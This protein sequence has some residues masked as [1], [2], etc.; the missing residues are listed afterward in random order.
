MRLQQHD[1]IRGKR[2]SW[3]RRRHCSS[4]LRVGLLALAGSV[5]QAQSFLPHTDGVVHEVKLPGE[6][7]GPTT[8]S[9]AADGRLWFTLSSGNAIGRVEADGSNYVQF[10]LPQPGSSPRIIALGS[11]GNLWFS[12]HDGGRMGRITPEGVISEWDLPTPDS[13]PRAIALG[14]DGNIWVGQFAAGSIARITPQGEITEFAIPTPDSGPRALAAGPDGNIWFSEF[15][16]GKIGRIT[17]QGEITEFALPRPNTGPGD[18]T[19]GSDGALWFLEL[20]GSMDGMQKDG[21]RVGR[22]TVEGEITEY[23]IPSEGSTPVNIALG[24]DGNI[25][26]TKNAT[27][28]RVTPQGEITEFP[29]AEGAARAV[30]LSAGADREPPRRLIDRLWFTDPVNNRIAYLQFSVTAP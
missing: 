8:L 11:D 17:P 26:Y 10:D 24:P 25:W 1:N 28:G 12:Q 20:G 15:K 18:I 5:C 23:D 13:Q 7:L 27:L 30:G 21:N 14:S 29:I 2:M 22:I 19:T 16:T 6:N 3:N 4:L 9:V